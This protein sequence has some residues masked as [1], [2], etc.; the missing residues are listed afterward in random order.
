MATTTA[1]AHVDTARVSGRREISYRNHDE[2]LADVERLGAGG[3]RQLGNWSLGQM[4]RHLASAMNTA[5]DGPAVRAA[6]PMRFVARLLFKNKVVRGPMK[7]GFQ[8]PPKFAP[9]LV[10]AAT[11]DHEGID[12]LRT[13][14]RR[15]NSESQRHPHGF[16]GALTPAEWEQLMLNHAAMHM[17]F[18]LPA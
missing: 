2:V 16:F 18:L 8:L 4:A 7:P 5:L 6:W 11:A 14:V 3:Y 13:A 1:P 15:W 17:S 9:S 12:V 10:P